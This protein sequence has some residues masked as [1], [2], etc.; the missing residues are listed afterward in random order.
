MVSHPPNTY[1]TQNSLAFERILLKSPRALESGLSKPQEYAIRTKDTH[2]PETAM[3]S[4][5][6]TGYDPL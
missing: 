5:R 3:L 4:L 2:N 6:K 1:A